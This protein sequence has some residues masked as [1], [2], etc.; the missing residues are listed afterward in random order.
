MIPD[1]SFRYDG[2]EAMD[3]PDCSEPHLFRTLAQF[4][5][6]NK[7]VSRYQ[8]FL[9]RWIISDMLKT[10][11]QNFH[12]VDLGAGGCDIA[13]WLLDVCQRR[14]LSLKITAID[15]D[16]RTVSWAQKR[17]HHLTNLT[18]VCDSAFNIAHVT[19]ADYVYSNHFLHHL[20]DGDIMRLLPLIHTLP[21]RRYLLCDLRRS[22][23]SYVGFSL[24]ARP[25]LRNSL[26]YGDGRISIRKGFAPKE[27]QH[28]IDAS[29]LQHHAQ[30][31]RAFP[32]RLAIVGGREQKVSPV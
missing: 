5:W 20:S 1:L 9:K 2:P 29:N 12:L 25:L 11:T 23:M 18:I 14:G 19:D 6:I 27:L 26:A 21:K 8:Y 4:Q 13:I 15:A 28:F 7:V 16:S 32:G 24:F 3:Q 22:Y 17:Y 30:I 10:P 31:C